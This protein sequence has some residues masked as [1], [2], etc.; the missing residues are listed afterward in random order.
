[1]LDEKYIEVAPKILVL[2]DLLISLD[3]R[4]VVRQRME[5]HELREKARAAP[6]IAFPPEPSPATPKP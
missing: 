6:E 2:D 5:E 3:T 4:R 1:M